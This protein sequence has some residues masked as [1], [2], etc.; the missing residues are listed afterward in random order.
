MARIAYSLNGAPDVEP[1]T[2]CGVTAPFAFTATLQPGETII[3]ITAVSTTGL[4]AS[5]E[6]R[7]S[8]IPEASVIGLDPHATPLRVERAPGDLVRVSWQRSAATS[9]LYEGVVASLS[10][11]ANE[12][13]AIAPCPRPESEAVIPRASADTY[14]LVTWSCA[15]GE[16]SY[17]R[18]A[19][20]PSGV[21]GP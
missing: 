17:G 12:H 2:T 1:R 9:D 14:Y 3:R 20:I 19:G 10:R 13:V 6:T 18:A 16:G 7:V 21:S 5:A 8:L 11:A 4:A 15:G